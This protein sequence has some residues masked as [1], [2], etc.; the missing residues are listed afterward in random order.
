M[1]HTQLRGLRPAA[2]TLALAAAGL[3]GQAGAAGFALIEQ[4]SS[5]QGYAHAGAAAAGED[6]STIFFNPAAMTLL[7]GRQ[8]VAG[9]HVV[10]PQADFN[11]VNTR[12][13]PAAGGG[14]IPGVEDDG[15]TVGV[16]PNFYYVMD[17]DE[18]TKFGLGI[19]APFGLTTEY[20]DNWV[21]RYHAV[22]SSLLTV[23]INPSLAF[24]M[25]D[26]F[27]VGF[28]FNLMYVSAEL[29]SAVDFGT[30]LASPGNADGFASVEG[31]G[32]SGGV[33]LGLLYSPQPGSRIGIA[34]RSE[35]AAKVSGDGDFTVNPAAQGADISA[36]AGQPAGTLVIGN[37][38]FTDTGV[39]AGVDLPASLSFS[40]VTDV[41]D[42][43]T[44]LFDITRTYWSSFDELR[45]VYDNPLQPDSVTTEN[46]DNSSRYAIGASYKASDAW[47]WRAGVAYDETPVKSAEFRTPRIPDEDRRWVSVGFG[48][49]PSPRLTFDV[50]YSHLFV[51]DTNIDNTLESALAPL[52]ATINGTYE[53]SV[54]I[55][56]AQMVY[57]F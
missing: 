20:D 42:R 4:S 46:W 45:I 29:T 6:A 11:N 35:I 2:L 27:S 18:R 40:F 54:D 52:N 47:T 3:S 12:F 14:L 1:S 37:T 19:N 51:S 49:T 24:E 48:Y 50:S 5:T 44:L 25:T 57:N 17:V 22:K 39:Q 55:L 13:A 36:A 53:S 9:L 34:Y 7:E 38:F 15:G 16:I 26:D 32:W 28:G 33:N 8:V 41:T 56:S 23:N 30:L 43:W 31:D 21:G 10:A